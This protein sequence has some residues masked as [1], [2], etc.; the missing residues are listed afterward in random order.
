ML[1]MRSLREIATLTLVLGTVLYVGCQVVQARNA[2]DPYYEFDGMWWGNYG[3]G[4][5]GARAATL[6]ALA[7]LRMPVY[8]EGPYFNGGFID[9]R[10]PENLGARIGI[11]PPIRPGQG[12][13]ICVRIGGFGTH[14]QVCARILDEI[15]RHIDA[16][17]QLDM[18]PV[19]VVP[20]QPAVLPGPPTLLAVPRQPQAAP[21]GLP[22]QPVPVKQ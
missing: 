22:P 2:Y 19:I 13:R 9:T 15:A 8:G 10:T 21:P 4:A 14:R 17:R 12:T 7:E 5:V 11:L 6:A 20:P 1:S 3:I 16:C 18:A